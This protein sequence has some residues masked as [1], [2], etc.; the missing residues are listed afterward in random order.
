M[1]ELI[2]KGVIIQSTELM[3]KIY[4]LPD[5][6]I[7][8]IKEFVPKYKFIFTNNDNYYLYHPLLSKY[9]SNYENYIRDMIRR[10]NDF[11]F[12]RIIDENYKRWINI[13]HY[14]YKKCIF[15]NYLYFVIYYCIENDSNNCREK[16]NKYCNDLGLCKNLYKKNV[17]QYIRWR[18]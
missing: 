14:T 17:V 5:T 8:L 7:L 2:N 13:K 18:N 16:I 9:I 1:N 11:V 12:E 15:K 4:L 6:L 3:N 10:D